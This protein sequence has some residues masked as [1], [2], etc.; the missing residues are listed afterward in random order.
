MSDANTAYSPLP[1]APP[2]SFK[3]N[4]C[5]KFA[6]IGCGGLVVLFIIAIVAGGMWFKS[7]EGEFAGSTREGVRFGLVRDEEACF[8]EAQRRAATAT[9]IA[10][11]VGVGQ[12]M[13]GCLEYSK[14]TAGFCD[15][16]PPPTSIGRTAAWTSQ[17]CGD[18]AF[19]R[20]VIQVVQTYCVEGRPK[21]TAADTLLMD[22]GEGGGAPPAGEAGTTTGETGAD[23]SSF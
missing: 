23:S 16:V 12:F 8:Q 10:G 18:N 22:A 21:R 20:T 17:R 1:P 13:R 5:L 3:S 6:L 14:P 7:K 19:C 11:Q 15:N 2:S 4:G 9:T